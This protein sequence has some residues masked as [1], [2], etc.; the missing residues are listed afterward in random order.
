MEFF[1]VS[2]K[3]F[4]A[5]L[6]GEGARRV[7]GRWNPAGM[8]VIYTAEH[9]SLAALEFLAHIDRSSFPAGLQLATI[10]I[11]DNVTIY[12]PAQADL[13]PDWDAR[14]QGV[15]TV[16]FGRKWLETATSSVLRVPSIM[17]PYRMGWNY[18]LNP[19][20]PELAGRMTVTVID[21]DVDPR[22]LLT[23]P[24]TPH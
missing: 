24:P 14:P 6:T 10:T 18:I 13:P 19:L 15:L 21:W 9:S 1:R 20:H 8:P 2:K 7:G 3:A 22:I 4:A 11:P 16:A 23:I 12:S 5:E 17:L